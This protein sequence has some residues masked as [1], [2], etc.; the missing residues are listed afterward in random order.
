MNTEESDQ[1]YFEYI[2][3]MYWWAQE[4]YMDIEGLWDEGYNY[5]TEEESKGGQ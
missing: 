1:V 2:N 4:Q 3:K 5:L